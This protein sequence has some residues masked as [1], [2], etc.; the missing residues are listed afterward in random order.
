MSETH[1][2]IAGTAF[3]VCGNMWSFLLDRTKRCFDYCLH[4]TAHMHTHK[5]FQE[6]SLVKREYC[7]SRYILQGSSR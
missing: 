6:Y 4:R 3:I 5:V 2:G 7:E 1:A